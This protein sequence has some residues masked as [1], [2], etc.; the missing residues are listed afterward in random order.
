MTGQWVTANGFLY[1]LLNRSLI[2]WSQ[3][4]VFPEVVEISNLQALSNEFS[5]ISFYIHEYTRQYS[6]VSVLA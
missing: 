4:M 3:D 6:S 1:D 2:F 5:V